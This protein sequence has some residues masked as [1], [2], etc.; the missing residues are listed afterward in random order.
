MST[1]QT[2]FPTQPDEQGFFFESVDD[3]EKGI[4]T[5]THENGRKVKEYVLKDG[6]L[7]VVRS[8][9]G[10]D[11]R[12]IKKYMGNDPDLYVSAGITIATT[13]D[14][15]KETLEFFEDLDL[16]EY[17]VLTSMFSDLNF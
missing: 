14:G 8:L 4:K 15:K 16:K 6:R 13:I 5:R 9:K 2:T 7:S 17:N 1:E 10:K 11:N 12:E 3:Q